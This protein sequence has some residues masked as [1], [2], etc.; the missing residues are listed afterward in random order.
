M[1]Y[2]ISYASILILLSG[3]DQRASYMMM[4]DYQKNKDMH[5]AI[6]QGAPVPSRS[7]D[8]DSQCYEEYKSS[9]QDTRF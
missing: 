2:L 8:Q 7:Y 9:I 1:K 4:Q 6:R 5:E 3:C